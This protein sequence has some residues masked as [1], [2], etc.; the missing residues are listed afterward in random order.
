MRHLNE[1]GR[2]MSNRAY[3]MFVMIFLLPLIL[4]VSE[5]RSADKYY[6]DVDQMTADGFLDMDQ[7]SNINSRILQR[8]NN[9][10]LIDTYVVISTSPLIIKPLHGKGL[11]FLGDV[12]NDTE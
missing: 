5:A 3:K 9:K 4:A 1:L 6:G 8:L 7:V 2:T 12:Y 11:L 10:G